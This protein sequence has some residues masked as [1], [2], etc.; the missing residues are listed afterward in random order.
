[1]PQLDAI[2]L[3]ISSIEVI[4]LVIAVVIDSFLAILVYRSDN[5]NATNKIFVL[6]NI[7]TVLW[8]IVSY[9]I[10][11]PPFCLST[12]MTLLL[13]RLGIFFAAPMS[14]LFLMLAHTLPNKSLR[15]S[16]DRFWTI[17]FITAIMMVL[18]ISPYAFTT[19]RIESGTIEP[20]PGFGLIPFAIFST[21]FSGL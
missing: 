17:I 19:V 6:L 7:F 21:L 8:L 4:I 12:S 18:N 3:S 5:K 11:I 10:R 20:Q 14:A 15:M 2:K 1:M 9:I 13:G 16:K